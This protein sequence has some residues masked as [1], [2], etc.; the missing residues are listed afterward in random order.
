MEEGWS[1]LGELIQRASLSGE[2]R[3]VLRGMAAWRGS[4]VANIPS[5]L[6]EV[7][8][9]GQNDRAGTH[10]FLHD[11]IE[12]DH[13][14]ALDLS[15]YTDGKLSDEAPLSLGL[16]RVFADAFNIREATGGKDNFI[17]SR[18]V[19]FSLLT[20]RDPNIREEVSLISSHFGMTD[21][22]VLA[23]EFTQVIAN[24]LEPGESAGAWQK[25]LVDRRL[26]QAANALA[27]TATAIAE[28]RQSDLSLARPR[29]QQPG[30][31]S[32]SRPSQD[33]DVRE[34]PRG[35]VDAIAGIR[36]DD[37]RALQAK[38]FVGIDGAASALARV[39]T[40]RG[41]EPPLAVGVFGP[42]GS[43]KSFFMRRVEREVEKLRNHA[44]ET[45]HHDIVEVRF[46]AWHY[47]DTNLWANLVGEVFETLERRS[48]LNISAKEGVLNKLSTAREL[49]LTTARDL[50][51]KR[52]AAH[53]AKDGLRRAEAELE[54]KRKSIVAAISS[55]STAASAA[56]KKAASD[57][58][59]KTLVDSTYGR[60]LEVLAAQWAKPEAAMQALKKD[61]A[62]WLQI[63][64]GLS[65]PGLFFCILFAAFLWTLPMWL[66][67]IMGVQSVLA[68]EVERL[69][70]FALAASGFLSSASVWLAR[71]TKKAV[72]ARDAVVAAVASYKE[73][74]NGAQSKENASL[75]KAQ[76]EYDS[77]RVDVE[78]AK[79]ALNEAINIQAQATVELKRETPAERL[80][81]FVK[82]KASVDGP[83]RSQQGL[84]GTI[85][86]DFSDLS[87]L[88]SASDRESQNERQASD[89]VFDAAIT[90]LQAEYPGIL[91]SH[92][93]EAI[94]GD[95]SAVNDAD[96]FD[97]IILY[98]DDLDRCPADK[99]LDVLQAVH[100][101]MA[102]RLFVVIVAVDVRWLEAALEDRHK[103]FGSG[104]EDPKALE[105]LEKIFQL[106][107]WTPELTAPD[108]AAFIRQRLTP[109]RSTGETDRLSA[110]VP[111]EAG[112]IE[113][114]ETAAR[115]AST[116][117]EGRSG[118][119]DADIL[120]PNDPPK[121]N[122]KL[123]G[124]R[125][126]Q[127]TGSEIELVEK[128]CS[129]LTMTP[130]RVL[131]LINSYQVARASLS[132]QEVELLAGSGHSSFV[133]LL[134]L[135]V[136]FPDRLCELVAALRTTTDWPA[137]EA[138]LIAG[139]HQELAKRIAL[140]L[141]LMTDEGLSVARLATY[142][143]LILRFSFVG[144]VAVNS[145]VRSRT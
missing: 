114:D 31:R 91:A 88:M 133:A 28:G 130:R 134:A 123:T 96:R 90:Q 69:G 105:Y 59:V 97:R 116:S 39:I 12:S 129:A 17:G 62:I 46:N 122:E 92:E 13:D 137:F 86:R 94:R 43:G 89:K 67:S 106:A 61:G 139:G 110:R 38:D 15:H 120:S 71:L 145:Y 8:R 51:S 33:N 49:T 121:H 141:K 47:V 10:R 22:S 32:K 72:L 36:N 85:R 115:N 48:A 93:L 3:R 34:G 79:L 78:A 42:W 44:G 118:P 135:S 124:H 65:G 53:I 77:A 11:L 111:N 101:L 5:Y 7:L 52:Q 21:L 83:Y 143:P 140:W 128:A 57:S 60:P 35:Q 29:R 104:A 4:D 131:R 80:R 9:L 84:I 87:V 20:T 138:S 82:A 63:R 24:A 73:A 136:A 1:S 56:W 6:A 102:F 58:D 103:Q 45:Y 30:S 99:V 16:S 2:I 50:A 125:P 75:V 113:S 26:P 127:L 119:G 55:A 25:I 112:L 109:T 74:A 68:R 108:T 64:R 66:P 14:R 23:T 144:P 70:P 98:I 18:H 142:I 107:I 41:F 126:L 54:L 19:A 100:L 132:P 37:P 27:S 117:K 76:G 40:A 81:A 95:A